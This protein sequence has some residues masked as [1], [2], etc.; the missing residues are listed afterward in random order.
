MLGNEITSGKTN[1]LFGV[2][3]VLTRGE[4]AIFLHKLST[5]HMQKNQ[6]SVAS[7]AE[8][9]AALSNDEIDKIVFTK[10]ITAKMLPV[11]DRDIKID[12]NGKV[13][14]GNLVYKNHSD[15][16]TFQLISTATGGV[17]QGNLTVDVPRSDF[18][19]G[20]N[21]KVTGKTTIINVKENTF[22]NNGILSAVNTTGNVKL[23][24]N[25]NSVT[26]NQ[27]AKVTV[28]DQSDI[29]N[30]VLTIN[31][32]VL[33]APIGT[34]K[35]VQV[36][37]G[38]IVKDSLGKAVKTI[39][40]IPVDT[41]L[42]EET[43]PSA[44]VE[45][46]NSKLKVHEPKLEKLVLKTIKIEELIELDRVLSNEELS[47]GVLFKGADY[48]RNSKV[49][50]SEFAAYIG[51]LPSNTFT[52][53]SANA[54]VFN[55]LQSIYG[56]KEKMDSVVKEINVSIQK[57]DLVTSV[58]YFN[59]DDV[60][61]Q[62]LIVLNETLKPSGLKLSELFA[63]ADHDKNK[64]VDAGEFSA[65]VGS[66][67]PNTIIGGPAEM[68]VFKALQDILGDGLEN[69]IYTI[70]AKFNIQG[71]N[72]DTLLFN[73]VPYEKLRDLNELLPFRSTNLKTLLTDA[74][75]DKSG[76]ISEV[77]FASFIRGLT[78]DKTLSDSVEVKII[79]A[80]REI[81]K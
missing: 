67:P 38:I 40:L 17:L 80:L 26:I 57:L 39:P 54:K 79:R 58:A 77:E 25:L 34:V 31:D 37:E 3:Q 6:L 11:L 27:T 63:A 55:V 10:N 72:M 74:D 18:V 73:K 48:D 62:K 22:Y 75:L 76:E 56:N 5:L 52:G 14:T 24:G 35:N 47:L 61:L 46:I 13:L 64:K 51:N 4:F 50:E 28:L 53:D 21:V 60:P 66:L 7:E 78:P 2:E 41:P 42:N 49:S 1:K 43:T 12:L 30:L 36:A 44:V 19:I 32:V 9:K 45:S 23:S 65:Y 20:E 8:L 16:E 70:N 59:W 33:N 71:L 68:K 29:A 69:T 15:A 81:Y